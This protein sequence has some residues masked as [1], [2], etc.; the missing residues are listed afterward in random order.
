MLPCNFNHLYY[1]YRVAVHKSVSKASKELLIAQSALSTQ[2]KQL[3][4]SMETTLFNRT[5]GGMD[6][7]EKGDLLFGYASKMFETFDEMKRAM[8]L[9]E[10]EVK[11]PLNIAAVHSVGIYLLP[12]ILTEYHKEYS[13]VQINLELHS[14]NRVMEILQENQADLAFIAWN[15]QYPLLKSWVLLQNDLVLAAPAKH[16]LTRKRKVELQDLVNDGFIG[17]EPGTPTR[18]MID[19]HFKN[20]GVNLKYVM[21]CANIATMKR[22]VIEGMGLAFLPEISVSAE[23]D[24]K[25]LKP[26]QV[27]GVKLERPVTVYW[28]ERRVLPR[29][30][31]KMLQFME[32]WQGKDGKGKRAG[33]AA[34]GSGR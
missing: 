16:P 15:R 29:P 5:K 26:I 6:L 19:S 12:R 17:Y 2:L 31:Q 18:M 27:E 30:A 8:V 34:S 32:G 23:L 3:E 4:E 20:L 9:A 10:K 25:V 14:S 7:T 13:D 24:H 33:A 21:E 1:F 22:L 11:G 28:K